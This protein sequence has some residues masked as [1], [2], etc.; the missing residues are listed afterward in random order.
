MTSFVI[1]LYGQYS[2]PSA[3]QL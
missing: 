1:T 3:P 2:S